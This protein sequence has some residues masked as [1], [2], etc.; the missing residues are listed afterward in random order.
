ML[1]YYLYSCSECHSGPWYAH[2]I[3]LGSET[4]NSTYHD[5]MICQYHSIRY[6]ES[7]FISSACGFVISDCE[8]VHSILVIFA[9]IL[10]CISHP[11]YKY[12]YCMLSFYINYNCICFKYHRVHEI[13]FLTRWLPGTLPQTWCQQPHG[14]CT[15]VWHY[16]IHDVDCSTSDVYYIHYPIHVSFPYNA[17]QCLILHQ[18][19]NC[20]TNEWPSLALFQTSMECNNVVVISRFNIRNLK[21]F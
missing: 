7:Q 21:Q 15:R 4:N 9:L 10:I 8:I 17:Y 20:L 3:L 19:S 18:I 12:M 6:F 2:A 14:T 13:T 1:Y 16:H 5:L 11:I